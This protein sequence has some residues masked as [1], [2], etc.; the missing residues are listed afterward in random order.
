MQTRGGI[1]TH[2]PSKREA[3][4]LRLRPVIMLNY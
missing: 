4:D 1:R 2:N 3:T